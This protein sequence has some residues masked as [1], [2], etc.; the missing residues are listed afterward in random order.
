MPVKV[1]VILSF[2]GVAFLLKYAIDRELLVMP[3]EFRLVAVAAA[4]V[5]LIFIGW[6]LRHKASVYAVSLQG[7]GAPSSP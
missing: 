6:R 1:G 2:I 4:G 3:I 7:G 5:A